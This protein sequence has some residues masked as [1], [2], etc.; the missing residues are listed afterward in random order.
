MERFGGAVVLALSGDHAQ[1]QK[2]LGQ[3]VIVRSAKP[4]AERQRSLQILFGAR[5]LAPTAVDTTEIVQDSRVQDGFGVVDALENRELPL[6]DVSRSHQ[7]AAVNPE[8]GQ[9]TEAAG[10]GDVLRSQRPFDHVCR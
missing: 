1:V 5:I 6:Q 2:R 10:V 7:I 8:C 4:L 3:E 9:R